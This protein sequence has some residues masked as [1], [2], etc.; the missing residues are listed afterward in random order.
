LSGYFDVYVMMSTT[1]QSVKWFGGL[2][3][4][5]DASVSPPFTVNITASS[6]TQAVSGSV[7]KIS[8]TGMA[9]TYSGG[10]S[11]A[12]CTVNVFVDMPASSKIFKQNLT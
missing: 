10:N 2:S 9:P 3:T 12:L 4:A 8:K 6:A 7:V 11:L 5:L 1:D